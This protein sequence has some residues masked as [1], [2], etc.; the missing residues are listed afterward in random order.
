MAPMRHG[1]GDGASSFAA[2]AIGP[3][4]EQSQSVRLNAIG[5][6]CFRAETH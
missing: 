5:I 2:N 6:L 4:L 3:M 1:L